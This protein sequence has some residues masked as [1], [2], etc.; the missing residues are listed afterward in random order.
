[1]PWSSC[2]TS[3]YKNLTKNPIRTLYHLVTVATGITVVANAVY[4]YFDPTKTEIDPTE[5]SLLERLNLIMPIATAAGYGAAKILN[6]AYD[7]VSGVKRAKHCYTPGD[8]TYN[9]I[10]GT[11]DLLR[12]SSYSMLP[13]T[14]CKLIPWVAEHPG[15]IISGGWAVC[16]PQITI[17][18]TF[19]IIGAKF[20][21]NFDQYDGYNRRILFKR[22]LLAPVGTIAASGAINWTRTALATTTAGEIV[23]H[24]FSKIPIPISGIVT[25]LTKRGIFSSTESSRISISIDTE[26]QCCAGNKCHLSCCN[27]YVSDTDEGYRRMTTITETRPRNG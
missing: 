3:T 11:L 18:V 27:T 23:A 13:S 2:F 9:A 26:I 5:Q 20:V 16:T 8:A 17:S 4:D 6:Y 22:D 12:A 14:L 21:S 10:D 1:M 15:I 7:Y 25:A 19:G 24:T